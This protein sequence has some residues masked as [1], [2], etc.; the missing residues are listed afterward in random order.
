VLIIIISLA[1]LLIRQV[2]RHSLKSGLFNSETKIVGRI[3]IISFRPIV[4]IVAR[5]TGLY[6]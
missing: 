3:I 6:R 1:G 4:L 2:I 5:L